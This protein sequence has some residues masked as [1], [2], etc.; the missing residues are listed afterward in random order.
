[1]G[2]DSDSS[3]AEIDSEIGCI[4]FDENAQPE[5]IGLLTKDEINNHIYD[6]AGNIVER[7]NQEMILN[8]NKKAEEMQD[9]I[10]HT[11]DQNKIGSNEFKLD[12]Q[13]QDITDF[14]KFS[15]FIGNELMNDELISRPIQR[16]EIENL[17][18][19]NPMNN[20]HFTSEYIAGNPYEI[21]YKKHQKKSEE[22]ISPQKQVHEIVLSS[23]MPGR[24]KPNRIEF[25]QVEDL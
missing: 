24:F 10:K 6:I 23:L 2:I 13:K 21:Q 15:R 22:S 20:Q 1:V 9:Y 18:P 14:R 19:R 4:E 5:K 8:F 12:S 25:E 11:L 3:K 17:K 16:G 7:N